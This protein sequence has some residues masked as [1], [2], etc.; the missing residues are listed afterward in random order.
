MAGEPCEGVARRRLFGR[1]LAGAFARTEDAVRGADLHQEALGV[2]WA[3]AAHDHVPRR[4]AT[5]R[6]HVLLQAT[7]N[8]CRVQFMR[9]NLDARSQEARRQRSGRADAPIKVD[10]RDDCLDGP[11]KHAGAPA[12][13]KRPLTAA[14]ADEPVEAKALG[15]V[16]KGGGRDEQRAQGGQLAFGRKREA[17][18][19]HLGDDERQ[20]CIAEELQALIGLA[21]CPGV[22]VQVRAMRQGLGEAL[23][24]SEP[25]AE[26]AR[27][28]GFV[29][30]GYL[31]SGTA[32][33]SCGGVGRRGTTAPV[34]AGQHRSIA[35][36]SGHRGHA[37][38]I[39]AHRGRVEVMPGHGVR[40]TG[41]NVS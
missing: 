9:G 36:P 33:A 12:T 5:L 6:L 39:R 24:V 3:I 19:Q 35:L 14:R 21:G 25:H 10:R 15:N 40:D 38:R 4:L 18:A 28:V 2:H 20:D 8:V 13:G 26:Q 17:G 41:M 7:L 22:V 34:L 27:E 31:G 30:H 1:A 37:S 29:R 23:R 16:R 11:G 32:W